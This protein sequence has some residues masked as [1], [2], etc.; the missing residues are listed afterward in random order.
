MQIV[1]FE[2]RQFCLEANGVNMGKWRWGYQGKLKTTKTQIILA[3]KHLKKPFL[4][5]IKAVFE[6]KKNCFVI[7]RAP[8][9]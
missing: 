8:K 3:S 2:Y 9:K 6:K 4:P 1:Y 7:R 5:R